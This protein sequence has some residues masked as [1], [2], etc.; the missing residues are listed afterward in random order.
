MHEQRKEQES[1]VQ[2]CT[3][4]VPCVLRQE[5]SLCGPGTGTVRMDRNPV[6]V[7]HTQMVW[8]D[9]NVMSVFVWLL[10]QGLSRCMSNLIIGHTE[11]NLL[12]SFE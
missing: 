11:K 6:C 7:D 2:L 3:A 8:T 9:R 5:S 4:H 10:R 12:F 1:S